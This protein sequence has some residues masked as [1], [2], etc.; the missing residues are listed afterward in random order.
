MQHSINMKTDWPLRIMFLPPLGAITTCFGITIG[1]N[2]YIGGIYWPYISDTG[3]DGLNYHL[4]SIS[5]TISALM[6]PL[7]VHIYFK[8][9]QAIYFSQDQALQSSFLFDESIVI[10][11]SFYQTSFVSTSTKFRLLW[12]T[13]QALISFSAICL[14]SLAFFSDVWHPDA[15]FAFATLFFIAIFL[16]QLF[17]TWLHSYYFALQSFHIDPLT[18]YWVRCLLIFSFWFLI[19]IPIGLNVICPFEFLSRIGLE[20]ECKLHHNYYC[21]EIDS[22]ISKSNTSESLFYDYCKLS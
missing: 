18:R 8:R 3:R 22:F 13:A 19:Y 1:R 12:L 14:A 17:Q 9:M 20:K 2:Y 7:L 10:S 15:H 11:S 21:D 5:L 4:F 6:M 16:F